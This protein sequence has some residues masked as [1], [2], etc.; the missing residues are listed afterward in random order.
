MNNA[1]KE[2]NGNEHHKSQIVVADYD[3]PK[4]EVC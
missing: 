2:K 4:T 3:T 1:R